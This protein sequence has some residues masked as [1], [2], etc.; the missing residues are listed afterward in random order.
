MTRYCNII[1]GTL[2]DETHY[3]VIFRQAADLIFITANGHLH[4]DNI[5]TETFTDNVNLEIEERQITL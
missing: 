3:K 1:L 2:W 5:R 4:S